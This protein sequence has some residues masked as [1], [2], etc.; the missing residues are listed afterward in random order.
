M[1]RHPSVL[2]ID[3]EVEIRELLR[4][5]LATAGIEVVLAENGKAGLKALAEHPEIGV[6]ITDLM[7]PEMDGIE[8]LGRVRRKYPQIEVIVLT[9]HGSLD[10]ALQA[11]NKGAYDYLR[12]PI[13][14][15]DLVHTV[16]RAMENHR[17]VVEN[18]KHQENLEKMVEQLAEQNLELDHTLKEL[19]ATQAQLIQSEKM[20]S[21]G[22]LAAGLAHEINNPL[23]FVHSNLNTLRKY[24]ARIRNFAFGL[25][26]MVRNFGD[27]DLTARME[28]LWKREKMDHILTDFTEILE[29]SLEGTYRVKEIISDLGTF[30]RTAEERMQNADIVQGL[31]STLNLVRG[32]LK[33]KAELVTELNSLP[34]VRCNIQ[35]LNQVFLNL[36]INAM[37]AIEEPPGRI[38]V[39]T[40]RP[41][42]EHVAVEIGDNGSGIPEELK[43]RLFDPFFTTKEVGEGTGMGLA[44]SYR[45]VRWH[46]GRIEMESS[47][48][49]GS[50][51]R[52]VLPVESDGTV[53]GGEKP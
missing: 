34:E 48:G 30:S 39:R 13:A 4:E 40:F 16:N 36:L 19:H 31:R 1:E 46:G 15:E 53:E 12:K 43:S 51:F 2:A 23:G 37:Q 29:E 32:H 7:M 18:R 25:R 24:S 5:A 20:A 50:T 21:L 45:I 8:L 44:V 14:L 3:D 41:D 28:E 42:R 10:T 33:K 49:K 17:L 52:V 9:G 35:Q 11:I 6:V 38:T 47:P 22:Q 26:E 27:S